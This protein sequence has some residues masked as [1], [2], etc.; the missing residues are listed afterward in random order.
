MW[1]LD[2]IS[3]LCWPYEALSIT[4]LKGFVLGG[5]SVALIK[6]AGTSTLT[7]EQQLRM[8]GTEIALQPVKNK[9]KRDKASGHITL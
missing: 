7:L 2:G 4:R 1:P 6:T 3:D 5:N 9:I 8:A